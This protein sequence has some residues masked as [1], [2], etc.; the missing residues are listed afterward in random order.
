MTFESPGFTPCK[1]Y[2]HPSPLIFTPLLQI[3]G[4]FSI[5]MIKL[6]DK[7]PSWGTDIAFCKRI[8]RAKALFLM[9]G[10]VLD[11]FL[12]TPWMKMK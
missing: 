1:G 4:F 10:R 9:P 6:C 12:E 7:G 8:E 5:K 2:R 11:E 3:D